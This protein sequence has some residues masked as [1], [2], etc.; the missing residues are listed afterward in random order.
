M[1]TLAAF[2]AKQPRTLTRVLKAE[3][4]RNF[5][6]ED[7]TLLAGSGAA[8]SVEIG[9]VAGRRLFGTPVGAA[10]AGGTGDGGIGSIALGTLAKK[11]EYKITCIAAAA[12]GGRFGVVDPDGYA[13]ADA[14]VGD[15][16]AS[17]QMGFT[18]SDGAADFVVGDAF[19]ITVPEGDLKVTAIDFTKVDGSQRAAGVFAVN[20]EAPDGVD[21]KAQMIKGKA[22]VASQELLWPDGATDAQK[23]GAL[24]ELKSNDIEARQLG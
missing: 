9:T 4:D 13:L 12:D 3:I 16:Y 6:F 21:V 2:S 18:I 17:P 11:G 8:R 1:S 7:V 14:L 23:A 10:V 22:L 24:A 15:A 5:T 19:T 20:K